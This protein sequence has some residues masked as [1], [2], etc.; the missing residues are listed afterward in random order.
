MVALLCFSYSDCVHANV[1]AIDS[2][3]LTSSDYNGVNISC[4]GANDGSITL[5]VNGGTS[6]FTF[7]WSTGATTQ[8]VTS[9]VAG[10]YTVTVIDATNDTLKGTSVLI[11]ATSV[12][13]NCVNDSNV[14]CNGLADGGATATATGGIAPYTYLWSNGTSTGSATNLVANTYTVTATDANGCTSTCDVVITEPGILT[15]SCSKNDISCNGLTDGE[16]TV[17]PAGGTGPFSYLWSNAQTNSTATGLSA[18]TYT[19]TVTDS[20][21][22]TASCDVAITEPLILTAACVV[23]TNVNCNGGADGEATVTAGGGTG[24]YS[25]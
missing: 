16:T 13:V 22:C 21:G 23:D 14:T 8:N 18:A 12:T 11:E 24:P 1:S 3:K 7:M 17:T 5:T 4:N 9:L 19:V 25:Y 2:I 10:T 20:E 15:A 6:P